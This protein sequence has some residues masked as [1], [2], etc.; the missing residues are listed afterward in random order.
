M[1][2]ISNL[3]QPLEDA[4]TFHLLPAMHHW[5]SRHACISDAERRVLALPVHDGGLGIPI[6]TI[7]AAKQFEASSLVTQPLVSLLSFQHTEDTV[8]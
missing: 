2:G 1:P 7:L 8:S 6:P 5:V 3:L 4:I